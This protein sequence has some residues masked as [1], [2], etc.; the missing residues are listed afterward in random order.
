[1]RRVFEEDVEMKSEEVARWRRRAHADI[2]GMMNRM[3]NRVGELTGV[4]CPPRVRTFYSALHSTHG[5][6][7]QV[8]RPFARA[9]LTLA[10]FLQYEGSS[11]AREARVGRLLA[12]VEEYQSRCG[13]M[14]VKI[15]RGGGEE[16][17]KT[18]YV[19]YLVPTADEAVTRA[20]ASETWKRHPGQ[21]KEEQVEW[22][23][24][25]LP[26]VGDKPKEKAKRKLPLAEYTTQRRRKFIEEFEQ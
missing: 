18:S 4:N 14:F 2:E 26:R 3:L 7:E 21:A 25:E 16:H 6:G 13:Y 11:E 23:L 15:T 22:A 20:R 10:Q 9:H 17:R 1:M 5:G 19:D 8:R 24:A 12:Q